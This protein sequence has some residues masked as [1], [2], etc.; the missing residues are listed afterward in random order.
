MQYMSI[1]TKPC[2][3]IANPEKRN[4]FLLLA[5]DD[6]DDQELII[7]L[8]GQIDKR[9][10]VGRTFNGHQALRYLDRLQPS[11]YPD[12]ILLDYKMP[13]LTGEEVLDQLAIQKKYQA[14]P[15][16]ILTSTQPGLEKER[17]LAAG[18]A[19]YLVKSQKASEMKA[20]LTHVLEN[21]GRKSAMAAISLI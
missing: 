6:L 11:A 21:V 10:R 12:L 19:Q 4:Y 18:A 14:I 15:K 16:V 17:C 9:W 13:G 8:I 1:L 20:M 5:E 2:S 7:E 3:T